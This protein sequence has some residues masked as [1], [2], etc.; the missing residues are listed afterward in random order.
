MG[1][2]ASAVFHPVSTLGVQYPNAA[3]KTLY[4]GPTPQVM[5]PICA[6][7]SLYPDSAFEALYH[8]LLLILHKFPILTSL[9]PAAQSAFAT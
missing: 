3:P 6:L 8:D 9:R 2:S 7:E 1:A 5:Y 4:F